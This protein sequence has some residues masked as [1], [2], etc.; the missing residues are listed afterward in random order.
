MKKKTKIILIVLTIIIVL[1]IATVV[2]IFALNWQPI[3]KVDLATLEANADVTISYGEASEVP[4]II[5]GDYTD[6]KVDS[7]NDA[8]RALEELQEVFGMTN[9]KEEYEISNE[10]EF[11][12]NKTYRMQQYYNGIEVIDRQ[13]VVTADKDGNIK[14]VSGD[15]E[16]ITDLDVNPSFDQNRA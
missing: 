3:N 14:M 6:F 1:A 8:I 5:A 16:K 9:P 12:D 11:L 10:I 2:T 15:Y 4:T 7:G 13:M